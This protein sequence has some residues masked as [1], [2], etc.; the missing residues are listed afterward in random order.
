MKLFEK[1]ACVLK[2]MANG[3][4]RREAEQAC[5]A[6]PRKNTLMPAKMSNNGRSV[7]SNM[8]WAGRPALG[9]MG[10]AK[11]LKAS[12][13]HNIKAAHGASLG[14]GA[15]VRE[16][17]KKLATAWAKSLG[18]KISKND[19]AGWKE[20]ARRNNMTIG[21]E[22]A[23]WNTVESVAAVLNDLHSVF[24]GTSWMGYSVPNIGMVKMQSSAGPASQRTPG[25][26]AWGPVASFP[27]HTATAGKV[28]DSARKMIRK[29]KMAKP[30]EILRL[31]LDHSKLPGTELTPEDAKLLEL[32]IAW[33]QNG[34]PKP[35]A[36]MSGAPGG[37]ANSSSGSTGAV[38]RGPP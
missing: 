37:P 19:R 23:G 4:S 30:T 5:N 8:P 3:M 20:F 11:P 15:V 21:D 27:F 36:K 28:W 17:P 16:E 13:E 10:G 9:Q 18:R 24:E 29:Y 22:E 35:V 1:Q 31:A 7:P 26:P 33:A 34:A 38:R 32:A 12:I 14:T 25:S 6:S 2:K